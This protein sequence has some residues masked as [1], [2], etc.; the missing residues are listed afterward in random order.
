MPFKALCDL[1]LPDLQ[2]HLSYSLCCSLHG[3]LSVPWS[4][5]VDVHFCPVTLAVPSPRILCSQIFSRL[6][7]LHD[8][9]LY[10]NV[11]SSEKASRITQ[12]KILPVI[13]TPSSTPC[14]MIL[15][16]LI[17]LWN[18]THLFFIL[19]V[20][21]LGCTFSESRDFTAGVASGMCQALKNLLKKQ[22]RR[23]CLESGESK[24][25]IIGIS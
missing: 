8:S 12:S 7:L 20:H 22:I 11:T 18:L 24:I 13:L 16:A 3:L 2:L 10:L 15:T 17:T 4:S 1:I 19:I 14:S 9:G 6:A 25:W 5:C 23:A 21:P